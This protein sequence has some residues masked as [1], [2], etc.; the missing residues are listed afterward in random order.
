MDPGD[1]VAGQ[2][3]GKHV[4]SHNNGSCVLCGR[5]LQ[6]VARLHNNIG[7]SWKRVISVWIAQRNS[8]TKFSAL[9][10]PRL[11]NTSPLVARRDKYGNLVLKFGG[12]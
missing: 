1:P 10:V 8:R 5:M 4:L 6:L 12:V 9:S 7:N 3:L 2:R 11:H